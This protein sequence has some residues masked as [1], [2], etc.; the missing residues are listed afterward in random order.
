MNE[1]ERLVNDCC[2]FA[3]EYQ[4]ER[5]K[6]IKMRIFAQRYGKRAKGLGHSTLTLLRLRPDLLEVILDPVGEGHIVSSIKFLKE[7]GLW[8][9]EMEAEALKQLEAIN[10]TKLKVDAETKELTPREK[11]DK[12]ASG[13]FAKSVNKEHT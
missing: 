2:D 1:L 13:G 4:C 9:A 3:Y 11:R 8:D 7:N 6:P 10:E 12:F 5:N